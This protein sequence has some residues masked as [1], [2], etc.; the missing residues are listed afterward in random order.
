MIEFEA[1]E[2]I[3]RSIDQ[4]FEFV[5]KGENN[6]QWNSAVK[7]VTKISDGPVGEGS[8]Y[9]M[10]RELPNGT[11]KN[12]YEIAEY[13]PNQLLTIKIISGPTPFVYR[14]EF[15][16]TDGSTILSMK[17]QVD[18]EGVIDVLGTKAKISPEFVL[19]GLLK[20]GVE[21]N[22]KTLKRILESTKTS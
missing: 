9:S 17:A 1:K 14:Y 11:S 3:N 20:K 4:V 10:T 13:E 19:S 18:K 12:V 21:T 2:T 5:A 22:L 15:E 16:G 7:L 8:Q 6:S